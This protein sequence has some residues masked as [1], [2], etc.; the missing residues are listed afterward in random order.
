[1]E[2]VIKR[3]VVTV[4]NDLVTDQR[5]ARVCETLVNQGYYVE[6]I[7]RRLPDSLPLKSQPYKQTR[8]K[9]WFNSGPLFYLELNVRLLLLLLF[10]KF[11]IVIAVD[12]DTAL[13]ASLV[14]KL[15]RIR[16]VLDAHELFSEVPE[17]AGRRFAK[18][19]W[20]WIEKFTIK[21]ADLCFTVS[22]SIAEYYS[23]L[24]KNK[25]TVLR[26]FP[27]SYPIN[28]KS[29]TTDYILY[30]GAVNEG[31]GLEALIE[32]SQTMDIKIKIAGAGDK[33]D[34]LKKKVSELK[35]ETKVEFL[36]KLSP[37]DLQAVTLKAWLG[38][39][40]LENKGL[41][42]YYSLSN[43]T[44][45]YIQAGVPQLIPLFPEY[46][47]LNSKYHFGLETELGAEQIVKSI[48]F[49]QTKPEEYAKLKQGCAEA[50]KNCNWEM[51]EKILLEQFKVNFG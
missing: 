12:A 1:M 36:G 17:L 3:V 8:R 14:R 46:Q 20:Q 35:L 45:D 21:K 6:L 28:E 16:F 51:E 13:A 9:L 32:A 34:V 49:L 33:L 40:L 25:F 41:S 47:K 50:A 43:K 11:D 22:E 18:R 2:R 39:N 5:M 10:K 48:K 38:F 7:G 44:F 30:Q 24:Y 4:S 29:I 26:N 27:R 15:K 31:R 42:Y 37:N 23:G 19:V